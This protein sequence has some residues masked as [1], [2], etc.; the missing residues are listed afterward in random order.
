MNEILP[1]L[2]FANPAFLVSLLALPL[3]WLRLRGRSLAVIAWRSLV[4]VLLLLALGNP[5]WVKEKVTITSEGGERVFAFDLSRSI[6]PAKKRWI[7]EQNFLPTPD[8]RV[9]VF[10]GQAREV[11]DWKRWIRGETSAA[12]LK[13]EKTNLE[14]LFST[15]LS[16]PPTQR[17]LYLFTDGWETQGAV[18]RLLPALASSGLKVF[19]MV[20][21]DP[22]EIPSVAIKGIIA[23][24]HGA[25]G[26]G[27]NLRVQVENSNAREIE[28]SLLLAR[29]G[30]PL[31]SEPVKLKP[32]SQIFNFQAT[33]P[34]GPMASFS[35]TFVP[36]FSGFD[37][38]SNDN[39]ATSWVSVQPKD[40]VLL[41]NGRNGQGRYL[42]EL[43]K[44]RGFEVIAVAAN[45]SPPAPTGHGIVI[46][47]EVEKERFS[48]AYLGAVERH[49]AAGNG[50]IM[51]GAEP[52]FSPGSYSRTSIESVLPVEP[53]EPPKKE[54]KNRAVVL[55]IDKSGSMREENKLLYAKEAAKAAVGQFKDTDL[56]GVVGFD[57]SAF[58]VVPLGPVEKSRA[59]FT[60]QLDRLKAAG[61]TYLYP[62]MVEAKR[63][64]EKQKASRK[65]MIILS[66]GETGGSGGDYLDLVAVMK[67]ELKI[68][69]SAV[70]IGGD[71]NIPL[72]S[73]IA[74]YGGGL[75]HHTHDPTTLPQI[76]VQQLEEKPEEAPQ[77]EKDLTP[78]PVK[79]SKIL[80]GFSETAYPALKGHMETEL[81]RG[82][83]L[84]LFISRDGR[85]LPLLASWI[86]G[87]GKSAA[88]TT[89]MDGRWS[90]E[91][92]R[93]RGLEGFWGRVFDWLRPVKEP[94]P[95]HEVRINL[96]DNQPVLDLYMFSEAGEGGLFRYSLAGNGSRET[97]DLRRLAPGHYQA[98]LPISLPGS[99]R[100]EL[101]QERRG[102]R[103]SYPTLGY[104][105]AYDPRTEMPRKD[106]NL[107]LLEKLARFS[108]GEINGSKE[109][110]S[111][112]REIT[113][114]R[115]P[116]RFYLILAAAVLLLAEII[117]RGLFSLNRPA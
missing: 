85:N 31:R 55:V 107:P 49:V 61:R 38:V 51:L 54:E 1:H 59:T 44:R 76:V 69:V 11:N 103:I 79:G 14:S 75:F 25:S 4:C 84:D 8:D 57:V 17:T 67:E 15:L 92:I 81:K 86:Y 88:F 110:L 98:T 94:L 112:N 91:W 64:L 100:I 105:L 19:P 108:G 72:L 3:L 102:Q 26:G 48:P 66:D 56:I 68:T 83:Q 35:V 89:D 93:W 63:Q 47:N 30:Q 74:K 22:P 95:P 111:Q 71:A 39:Q 33:L 52:S 46:F 28:G 37:A 36:R 62:A 23:P 18:E 60:A 27:I 58:V 32:G 104:T 82:A 6:P 42:E 99:Y 77:V 53:K 12:P 78:I 21:P 45:A 7:G 73:R 113:Y 24:H 101:N 90:R 16:L 29:N 9:F 70:A 40:K 109:Q 43:L 10:A 80:A 106:T 5:E 116:L 114:L 50:F 97:G 115:S 117:V 41:L 34:D 13:P 87:A 20:P 65:H 2:Q 96:R